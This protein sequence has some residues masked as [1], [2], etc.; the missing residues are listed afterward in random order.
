MISLWKHYCKKSHL[1]L[2]AATD[3]LWLQEGKEQGGAR[4][5]VVQTL[6]HG[7]NADTDGW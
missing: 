3:R 4:E 1:K 6:T 5:Q 2:G 7:D